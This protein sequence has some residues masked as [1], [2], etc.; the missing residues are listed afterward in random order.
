MCVR[1]YN[2]LFLLTIHLVHH[3]YQVIIS[4]E[5]E[6]IWEF[7]REKNKIKINSK[8]LVQKR[9]PPRDCILTQER[10]QE[11]RL[12]IEDGVMRI[13]DDTRKRDLP[14]IKLS[15]VG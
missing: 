15:D 8:L 4:L 1:I 6:E 11:A 5:I 10:V 3:D 13:K 14:I 7:Q 9:L 12:E 2:I